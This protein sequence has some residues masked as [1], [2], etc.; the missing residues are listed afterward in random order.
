MYWLYTDTAV[1][2]PPLRWKILD[3]RLRF[4]LA[5]LELHMHFGEET[6]RGRCEALHNSMY[7]YLQSDR[8]GSP[9]PE[10]YMWLLNVYTGQ[11]P[12]RESQ[13]LQEGAK[14]RGGVS[15]EGESLM[16]PFQ[17]QWPM[18][19]SADWRRWIV[20]PGRNE[21]IPYIAQIRKS[22]FNCPD[23]RGPLFCWDFLLRVF[24]TNIGK[25]PL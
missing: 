25:C 1:I 4:E 10:F 5:L 24:S 12:F 11:Q 7:E 19:R 20:G 15:M 18:L 22:P 3:T 13:N 14:Y 16:T 9:D 2:A 6:F 17:R 8:K 23:S 21:L